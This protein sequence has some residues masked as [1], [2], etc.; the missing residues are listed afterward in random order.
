[1]DKLTDSIWTSGYHERLEGVLRHDR[2]RLAA[3]L[4][5]VRY[6]NHAGIQTEAILLAQ[7]F[8]QRID[9]LVAFILQLNLPGAC[10]V[11]QQLTSFLA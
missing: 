6:P 3:Q 4:D 7:T 10:L 8:S 5:L 9:G 1:M 11:P 2:R